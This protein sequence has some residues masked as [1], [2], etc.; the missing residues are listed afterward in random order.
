MQLGLDKCSS[1][2]AHERGESRCY[3]RGEQ[4]VVAGSLE[5]TRVEGE[6]RLQAA[7]EAQ[8]SERSEERET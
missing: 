7:V 5:A 3:R 6:R 4:R 8:N 1:T 2:A